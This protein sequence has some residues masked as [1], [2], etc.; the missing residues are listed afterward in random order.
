[1]AEKNGKKKES[2]HDILSDL[3]GLL[4]RMPSLLDGIK[5]PEL[6]PVVFESPAN[7]Q[8]AATPPEP[9]DSSPREQKTRLEAETESE[10]QTPAAQEPV[11]LKAPDSPAGAEPEKIVIQSLGE[12][13]FAGDETGPKK[14]EPLPEKQE[15]GVL[16]S[17]FKN[18]GL[19]T[20][21]IGLSVP[22]EFTLEEIAAKAE[23]RKETPEKPLIASGRDG[24]SDLAPEPV[25]NEPLGPAPIEAAPL[26]GNTG[27]R[28][29]EDGLSAPEEGPVNPPDA[30][31]ADNAIGQRQAS[32]TAAGEGV[33]GSFTPTSAA[34]AGDTVSAELPSQDTETSPPEL[35]SEAPEAGKAGGGAGSY[36]ATADPG[37]P[38]ADGMFNILQG[39]ESDPNVPGPALLAQEEG[40]NL[41]NDMLKTDSLPQKS[42]VSQPD[43]ESSPIGSNPSGAETPEQKLDKPALTDEGQTGP[44]NADTLADAFG[45]TARPAAEPATVTG[46]EAASTTLSEK[47]P[48][49]NPTEAEIQ[50]LVLSDS[51]GL[52]LEPAPAPAISPAEPVAGAPLPPEDGGLVIEE[53]GA[54]PAGKN[55]FGDDKT[56]AAAPTAAGAE[57]TPSGYGG[58]ELEPA[59]AVSPAKPVA[60]APLPPED[61]G[62]V[63]EEPGAA[64]AGKNPFEDDKT[65]VIAS[66]SSSGEYEHAVSDEPGQS[67]FSKRSQSRSLDTLS[68]KQPPAAVP[69]ERI[70]TVAFLYSE[71]NE[72]LMT[73]ILSELDAICLK[74]ETKPMFVRRAFVKVYEQDANPNFI[75]KNVSASK[76]AGLICTGDIPSEKFDDLENV[77]SPSG[78]FLR[79]LT[80]ENFNHSSALDLILELMLR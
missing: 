43:T 73:S 60:G 70:I 4:N 29:I 42:G 32:V 38:D 2:I 28:D 72:S 64:P 13:L 11:S 21:P 78:L 57:Q 5:L 54:A 14:N 79:H 66:S 31:V 8:K 34:D 15:A 33:Q 47:K 12:S 46:E 20:K 51:D 76:A 39:K 65:L 23:T 36:E 9:P 19:E 52:G 80:A 49:L 27:G 62:L 44:Q 3:N 26:F 35:A 56:P 18:A 50:G 30:S 37:I 17:G 24:A 41:P 6:K 7:E 10:L 67:D 59:P 22:A 71:G 69:Q 58:L 61:G 74:S 48:E 63:I 25:E 40:S 75:L 77:F 68:K 53:P 1:M 45:Q 16:E 55:P